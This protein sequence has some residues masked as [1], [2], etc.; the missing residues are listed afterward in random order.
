M[1]GHTFEYNAA[2]GKLKEYVVKGELGEIYYIYSSKL[3][4]GKIRHDIN[5]MWNFALHDIS[6]IL[7]LMES[8]PIKVSA[9]GLCCIQKGIEDVVFM[10]LE[11][12]N[13]ANAH[14]D[15]SW[16]DP[17]KVRKMTIVSSKKMVIY[18]YIESNVKI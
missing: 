11:F 14:I 18:D 5:A 6:I 12:A 1:V 9:Q 13:G 17:N 4:L 10:H 3:N 8:E 15:I 7:Y 16:L 2:V